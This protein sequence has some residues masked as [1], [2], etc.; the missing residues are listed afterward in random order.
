MGEKT[1]IS[2][3]LKLGLMMPLERESRKPHQDWS[4][5]EAQRTE[6]VKTRVHAPSVFIPRLGLCALGVSGWRKLGGARDSLDQLL[7]SFLAS[8]VGI[9][10]RESLI[11][12][13][14]VGTVGVGTA[15]WLRDSPRLGAGGSRV[16]AT[17]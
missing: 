8:L 7:L 13:R 4:P 16:T 15:R 3:S 11:S 9:N 10:Q 2:W 12:Q 14:G 1:R 6:G 5:R 17:S